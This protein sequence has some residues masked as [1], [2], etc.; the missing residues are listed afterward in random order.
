MYQVNC[1]ARVLKSRCTAITTLRNSHTTY[2][3]VL[4][5]IHAV[6]IGNWIY[7]TLIT[8]ITTNDYDTLTN[9]HALQITTAHSRSQPVFTSRCL[10]AAL[11]NGCSSASPSRSHWMTAGLRFPYCCS[12]LLSRDCLTGSVGR[13]TCC[14]P[15]PP[16]SFLASGLAE[17]CDQVFFF[18]SLLSTSISA[19]PRHPG[20]YGLCASFVTALY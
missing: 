9:I 12:R 4:V 13:L 1:F 3:V 6:W 11:N 14:W 8:R 16:Q 20:H 2:C 19:L 10:V 17:N 5:T 15:S 18:C 7:C